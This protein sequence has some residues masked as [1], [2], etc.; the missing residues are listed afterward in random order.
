MDIINIIGTIID[1]SIEHIV[2]YAHMIR[3]SRLNKNQQ[4]INEDIYREIDYLKGSENAQLQEEINLLKE[5]DIRIHER[6]NSLGQAS[7]ENELQE[8]RTSVENTFGNIRNSIQ[9]QS[10]S[11]NQSVSNINTNISDINSD[12]TNINSELSTTNSKIDDINSLLPDIN[13]EFSNINLKI[14]TINS[15]LPDINSSIETIQ[16]EIQ[17]KEIELN[18]SI[19]SLSQST[20]EQNQIFNETL[21]SIQQDTQNINNR[22]SYIEQ[23]NIE[24]PIKHKLISLEDYEA[25]ESYEENTLYLIIE[26]KENYS[27]FGDAFPFILG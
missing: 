6:I 1:N 22:L 7:I 20:Q 24:G 9:E 14:S 13:T 27:V 11:F 26:S 17:E 19:E 23:G 4:D 10:N 16:Q 3:D 8:F 2:T 12:I 5:E 15:T 25:L 21:E 18:N